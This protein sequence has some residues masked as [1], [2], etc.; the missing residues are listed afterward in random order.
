MARMTQFKDKSQSHADN[1]NVGLFSYPVLMAAD[2][3][4]Y[5]ADLVPVG[6]DQ[7]QHLEIARDIASR[8]NGIYGKTFTIPDPYIGKQGARV[9]SLQDPTKKMSKSDPNPKSYV[10]VFDTPETIMKKISDRISGRSKLRPS[11]ITLA[12]DGTSRRI[13]VD[14]DVGALRHGTLSRCAVDTPFNLRTA[15]Q[16]TLPCCTGWRR[17]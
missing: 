6:A 12:L 15:P 17:G 2:I 7:K 11:C 10:S 4:L 5:Q 16:E 1:I 14:F 8:F 3:L 9:M 13:E